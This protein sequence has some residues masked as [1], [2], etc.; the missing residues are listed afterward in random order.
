MKH[1]TYPRGFLWRLIKIVHLKVFWKL[2]S[3]VDTLLYLIDGVCI[4]MEKHRLW[5]QPDLVLIPRIPLPS[6]GM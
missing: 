4:A 6:C 1:G 3:T 2:S 5:G